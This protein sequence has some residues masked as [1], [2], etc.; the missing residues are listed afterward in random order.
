MCNNPSF[1]EFNVS[2]DDLTHDLLL[3]SGLLYRLQYSSNIITLIVV[4]NSHINSVKFEY[5]RSMECYRGM[6]SRDPFHN[7]FYNR[8]VILV[9]L[10]RRCRVLYDIMPYRTTVS[11]NKLSRQPYVMNLVRTYI[12]PYSVRIQLPKSVMNQLQIEPKSS[13]ILDENSSNCAIDSTS[14][15]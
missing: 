14:I 5:Y 11:V 15:Y 13:R 10:H 12:F 2:S 4:V 3:T 8:R 9:T 7:R 6:Q 1:K